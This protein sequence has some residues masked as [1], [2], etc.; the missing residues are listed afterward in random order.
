MQIAVIINHQQFTLEVQPDDFLVDTLRA[1]GLYSVRR[2]C[3]T[4]SCGLCTVWL[5][6]KPTL[7]CSLLSFRAA[8]Q[9]ITT[10][11]GL[12]SEAEEFAQFMAAEGA[13]QCGYCSPGFIMTVLAMKRELVNPTEADMIHY[14]TG[15]LCRCTGYQGQL[16]AVK[17][18]LGV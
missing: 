9:H 12:R 10:I 2:G 13:D 7:S 3:E 16:R 11:E 8:G 15:N 1:Q 4:S 6:G 18:Y 14:L 5:N 17:K